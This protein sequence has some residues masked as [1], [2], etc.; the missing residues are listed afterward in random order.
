[1]AVKSFN[2]GYNQ[3]DG[4]L[5][6][7]ESFT[8][9]YLEYGILCLIAVTGLFCSGF[10]LIDNSQMPYHNF[11][12][13]IASFESVPGVDFDQIV[14]INGSFTKKTPLTLNVNLE[15]APA[16]YVLDMGDNSRVILTQNE[17]D[18]TFDHSGD[19]LLELKEINRGL[20][21]V[22][23]SKKITIK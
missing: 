20:I 12:K 23:A 3:M 16:R 7:N 6:S 15:L 10:A 2:Q 17:F 1:M 14:K 18:F 13:K 21:T 19:Y 9:K 11:D 5:T 8:Q 4:L 22:I